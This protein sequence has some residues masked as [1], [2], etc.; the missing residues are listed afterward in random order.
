MERG[1]GAH[2]FD[3]RI[4]CCRG[5]AYFT[6]T[7][8]NIYE[9]GRVFN[10][11]RIQ[12][13]Q[14]FV[15]V[16]ERRSLSAAASA[17][18]MS[19]P[20][21]SRILGTLE[22]ELGVRLIARNTRGLA[23]TDGGRLYYR[24][25]QRILAE[26]RDADTAVQS[27][28]QAPAGE[29]RITAPVTFGRFHVAPAIAQFLERHPRL[30]VYLSLSDQCESLSE[31]RLDVAIRVAAL[32]TQAITARR[33]G[34]V[35]RAVVGSREYFNNHPKPA[36][37]RDLVKHNCMHFSHYL[38]ADEWNFS[39]RGRGVSVKVRGRLR[40]NNQE[41]LMDAVLAGSGLAVLPT[42]LI[43]E[44]LEDGRLQ[45]VLTEFEAPRTPV[46]A[47]FPRNGVPPN[48]VR[49][50]VDFLADRYR[51]RDILSAE[52]HVASAPQAEEAVG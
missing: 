9:S 27:H 2:R 35:Q 39:D 49:V 29:L 4:V 8:C 51:E 38:R 28:T 33:L 16:F 21:V 48:K 20:S 50:V 14:V 25:C 18:G 43:R 22:R 19:L 36:H 23:E 1:G 3:A 32:R 24:R 37:P 45:R 17:L 7:S 47:V 52:S 46:D 30:S 10:V 42:W 5:L 40:T 13:M 26:I 31:Q 34:Y 44:Q 11:D 12:A 6:I 41:A 15:T